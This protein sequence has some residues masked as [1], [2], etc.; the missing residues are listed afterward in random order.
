MTWWQKLRQ[1]VYRS[2]C[3]VV[4]CLWRCSGGWGLG[5]GLPTPQI[6]IVKLFLSPRNT[7]FLLPVPII[8]H[9]FVVTNCY[10]SKLCFIFVRNIVLRSFLCR[11]CVKSMFCL[12]TMSEFHPPSENNVRGSSAVWKECANSWHP[13]KPRAR[14][15][16][17][18][19]DKLLYGVLCVISF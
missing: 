17:F 11:Y 18:T 12:K 14:F 4:L 3:V 13:I 15:K 9:T 1:W 8:D 7:P 10:T 6:I 5:G 16:I 19:Y 2:H